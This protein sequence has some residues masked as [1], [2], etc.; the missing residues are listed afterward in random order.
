[1]EW[2][3]AGFDDERSPPLLPPEDR[4]WRH[5]TELGSVPRG[6]RSSGTGAPPR[7][8]TVVALT[9][10]I[11][12]LLTLGVVA[13]TRPFGGAG[14]RSGET[15]PS[16][17]GLAS[18]TDVAAVTARLRPAIAKVRADSPEGG[19]K[20]GSGVIFREDGMMLTT[21]HVVEGADTL[22]VGL[23]DGREVSARLVGIDRETDIAVIDL[24]GGEFP[25]AQLA[26]GR[27]AMKLGQ[28]TMAIG[29]HPG[30]GDNGPVVRVTMVSAMGQEA[31]LDGRTFVDMIRMDSAIAPGCDGGALVDGNGMVVA[32]ASNNIGDQEQAVG[33]ATPI[34]VA[35]SIAEQIVA[36][37]KV[38][39][40]W[41]GIEGATGGKGV[42]VGTVLPDSPAATAGV[43]AGDVITAI[44][45]SQV[46]TMSALVVKLR[47][48]KP[49]TVT[50]IVVERNGRSRTLSIELGERPS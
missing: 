38:R 16:D 18:V 2:D 12:I 50:E 48:L 36:E 21:S 14:G 23:D 22:Q 15:L 6:G 9:S 10:C 1:M 8:I 7:M 11:S 3:E 4:L 28:R 44:D 25:T 27:E 37:G 26:P 46:S 20:W 17:G 30:P 47:A 34:D 33:Y 40:S 41:I 31:E 24:E 13:V 42:V 35:R 19:E 29:A 49:G 5:P 32:I 45:G 39:R 43:A